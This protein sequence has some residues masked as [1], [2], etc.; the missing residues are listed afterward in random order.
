[1]EQTFSITA[2]F[3]PDV[4]GKRRFVTIDGV[5]CLFDHSVEGYGCGRPYRGRRQLIDIRVWAPVHIPGQG[6]HYVYTVVEWQK[7]TKSQRARF[8]A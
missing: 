2:T 8:A 1:M 3:K 4:K 7:L 6:L 5:R